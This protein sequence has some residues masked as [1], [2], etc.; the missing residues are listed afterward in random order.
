ME[1]YLITIDNSE[2]TLGHFSNILYALG[3]DEKDVTEFTSGRSLI[4]KMGPV[5]L[6]F[7]MDFEMITSILRTRDM[8]D[9][10]VFPS[11]GE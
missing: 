9:I 4:V 6:G 8:K 3:V 10:K 5:N 11:N 7:I 1:N 2:V